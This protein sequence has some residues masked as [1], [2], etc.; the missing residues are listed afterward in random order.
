MCIVHLD[1]M[2]ELC[3]DTFFFPRPLFL[4]GISSD[5]S[6]KCR[7]EDATP[8]C[9]SPRGTRKNIFVTIKKFDAAIAYRN[10]RRDCKISWS[11][12]K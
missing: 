12:W 5:L 7:K 3:T 4:F 6:P 2:C 10:Y 9:S 11:D 8:S 1:G